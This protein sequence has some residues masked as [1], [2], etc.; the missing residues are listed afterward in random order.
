MNGPGISLFQGTELR[1]NQTNPEEEEAELA[2]EEK[3]KNAELRNLLNGAF[4]DLDINDADLSFTSSKN[5][6]DYSLPAGGASS[7][8][9]LAQVIPKRP[10][11]GLSNGHG[12]G[13][14]LSAHYNHCYHN[15]GSYVDSSTSSSPA[16]RKVTASGDA[17]QL[18]VM[19]EVRMREIVRLQDMLEANKKEANDRIE[20]LGHK[21]LQLEA[22]KVATNSSLTQTQTL[23]VS[24]KEQ[25]D[26]LKKEVDSLR[27]QNQDLD[28]IREELE[29]DRLIMRANMESL[30]SKLIAMEKISAETSGARQADMIVRSLE[31]RQRKEIISYQVQIEELKEKLSNAADNIRSQE[32]RNA[33]LSRQQEVML[34]EKADTINGLSRA[35]AQSQ[36]HCQELMAA[37]RTNSSVEI[38]RLKDTLKQQESAIEKYKMDID[39]LE[40]MIGLNVLT[41]DSAAVTSGKASFYKTGLDSVD[42][43]RE[44]LAKSLRYHESRR[45]EIKQLQY[46][47]QEKENSAKAWLQQEDRY[48][49]ELT[50]L[51]AECD[52][53]ANDL[54]RTKNRPRD[55]QLRYV[56]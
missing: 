15:K 44:E 29:Q 55:D 34:L 8:E 19:Y 43:L 42:S 40:T 39:H 1:L 36:Q 31:E 12:D 24:A 25:V 10:T 52:K 18:A 11:N 49:K 21:I 4:D 14:E 7:E 16:K 3:R 2:E 33:E 35:L 53:L 17:Q 38:R 54:A 23:L 46:T 27:K 28:E 50:E 51:K 47:I 37:D 20:R 56:Q 48:K 45:A 26:G 32:R 9:D 22:E 30:N 41:S 6:N 5:L 13:T